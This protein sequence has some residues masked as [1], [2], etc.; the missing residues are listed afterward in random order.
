MT[1][2]FVLNTELTCVWCDN[3]VAD[4]HAPVCGDCRPAFDKFVADYNRLPEKG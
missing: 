2:T 4:P 3:V 1:T